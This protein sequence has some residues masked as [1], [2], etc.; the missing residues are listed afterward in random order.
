MITCCS[1]LWMR[2]DSGRKRA[3]AGVSPRWPRP[4]GAYAVRFHVPSLAQ[5]RVDQGPVG[6]DGAIEVVPAPVHL[7]VRLESTI[8]SVVSRR[9]VKKQQ[10]QWTPE[11]AHLLLQVRTQVLNGDWEAT[12]RT[13]YPGFRSAIAAHTTQEAA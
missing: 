9:R 2:Q 10:L 8:N 12:F 1:V 6:V 13:W 7:H 3:V 11:G 5:H 4:D